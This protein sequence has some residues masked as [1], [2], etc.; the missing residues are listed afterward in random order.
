[1]PDNTG[2]NETFKNYASTFLG[3]FVRGEY[4]WKYLAKNAQ[5]KLLIMLHVPC[6]RLTCHINK[7]LHVI[8]FFFLLFL[9]FYFLFFINIFQCV[10]LGP[11]QCQLI[12]GIC[13][14]FS[15]A[16]YCNW[17]VCLFASLFPSSIYLC[18][19]EHLCPSVHLFF[20]M[21]IRLNICYTFT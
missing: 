4:V 2:A 6:D 14:F 17:I 3:P 8:F 13:L 20:K 15:L 16:K 11:K 21:W 9:C 12:I 10:F 18:V 7:G 19:C 5:N 1:L